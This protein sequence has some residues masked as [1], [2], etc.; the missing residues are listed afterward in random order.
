MQR[1]K[2]KMEIKISTNKPL[3]EMAKTKELNHNIN[4]MH[5]CGPVLKLLGVLSSS[6]LEK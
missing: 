3:K 4:V 5:D 1:E 2:D 6:R